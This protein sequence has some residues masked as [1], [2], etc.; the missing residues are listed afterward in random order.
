MRAFAMSRGV[1][2]MG[3]ARPVTDEDRERVRQLHA[4]GK[5]RN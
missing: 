3:K 5:G 2:A 4:E 1:T